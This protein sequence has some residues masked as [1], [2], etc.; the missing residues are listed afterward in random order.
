MHLLMMSAPM[1]KGCL[2]QLSYLDGYVTTIVSVRF[3]VV[4]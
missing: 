1:A 2:A 3:G 4:H